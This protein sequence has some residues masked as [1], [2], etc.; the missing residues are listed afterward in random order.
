M[1]GHPLVARPHPAALPFLAMTRPENPNLAG[2]CA[3]TALR[4]EAPAGQEVDRGQLYLELVR[5]CGTSGRGPTWQLAQLIH[6]RR[7]IDLLRRRHGKTP[8]TRRYFLPIEE[9]AD[10][11]EIAAADVEVFPDT[12]LRALLG[13]LTA[14]ER[15]IVVARVIDQEPL[16]AIAQRHGVSAARISQIMGRSNRLMR[17]AL[18]THFPG[19]AREWT[20]CA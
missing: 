20:A 10:L 12:L 18:D 16:A 6:R 8:R 5:T 9:A 11:P 1:E 2:A 15:A 13:S 19:L 14:R 17:A 3:H 4:F 7:S